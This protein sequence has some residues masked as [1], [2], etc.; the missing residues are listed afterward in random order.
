M[1]VINQEIVLGLIVAGTSLLTVVIQKLFEKL[2]SRASVAA[3]REEQNSS[4]LRL[5]LARKDGELGNLRIEL[6]DTDN[7]LDELRQKYLF[8]HEKMFRLRLLTIGILVAQGKTQEEIDSILPPM[9]D[10]D[11]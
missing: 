5:D 11:L 7:Q 1:I 2:I 3:Q 6:R 9:P 10:L 4:G 8:L